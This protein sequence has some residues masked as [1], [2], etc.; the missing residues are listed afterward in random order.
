MSND[1]CKAHA[2][3]QP[4]G[5]SKTTI[6][7]MYQKLLKDDELCAGTPDLN[8]NGV[9]DSG[10][11]ACQGDSGGPLIC[12]VGG[13][14]TIQGVIAWGVGCASEGAP[15]VF[16][17]VHHFMNWIDEKTT[18]DYEDYDSHSVTR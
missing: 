14:A 12:D 15:G 2:S 17:N 18:A 4:I 11:D 13:F 1:Y 10:V 5:N 7:Q 3:S 16:A 9:T 6:K 8:G